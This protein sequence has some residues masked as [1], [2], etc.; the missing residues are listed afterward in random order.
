MSDV[1]GIR[2]VCVSGLP[3]VVWV[4]GVCTVQLFFLIIHLPP[5]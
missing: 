4:I 2:D 1:L 5:T 3:V